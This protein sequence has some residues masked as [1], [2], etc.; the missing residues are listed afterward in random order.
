MPL[1]K[2]ML[3]V[4]GQPFSSAE[5]IFEPKIDGTRC[6][7]DVS[8]GGV[9]LY[10]RRQIDI[11][12]RYPEIAAALAQGAS[13][14]ILDGEIAVFEDGSPNFS[15]LSRREHQS[16]KMRIEYLSSALPA[17]YVVFDIL[18]AKGKSVMGLPL[19]QRKSL[20][21]EEIQESEAV[22]ISD[23][24]EEKGEDY[25]HAALKMGIEGVVA[26]RLNSFYQPGTRSPD[27][28][29]IK[30]SLK[31]D[32]VV[33]GYIPG[34]GG[35]TPYFGGLLLGAYSHGQLHYMGR[36]GSGFT[37]RELKEITAG[38]SPLEQSPFG[39]AP[40]TPQARWIKPDQVVQVSLLE[41]TQDGHLRAPVFLRRRDDKEPRECTLDQIL[42][43]AND[44]KK[45]EGCNSE[46]AP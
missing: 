37:E 27:W 31:L 24:F 28:I 38:F 46:Q 21:P 36:V 9:R 8:K 22:A 32:L 1:V 41:V 12:S 43:E 13:D 20:L 33:G 10:N 44:G 14:C 4:S 15:A 42:D 11:T 7:A 45:T 5:W 26:K 2:P 29:K 6:L 30:K 18:Y 3:A 16:E 19:W 39:D 35:R 40:L 17:N 25:F 23:S 34:K